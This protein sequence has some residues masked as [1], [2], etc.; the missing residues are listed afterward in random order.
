MKIDF[1][2][3]LLKDYDACWNI[4][5]NARLKMIQSGLHQWSVTYPST[6]DIRNDIESGIAFVLTVDE[7]IAVYGAVILNGEPRYQQ[8][9]GEW[10]TH[11]DYYAIH[12]FATLPEFQREGFAK[13]FIEKINSMCELEHVPSI[14]VDTHISNLPMVNLLSSMGFCYCGIVDYG[15]HGLRCAFEKITMEQQ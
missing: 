5:N 13:V 2:T 7:K 14:K 9:Q 12:R 6:Q 8:L 1:R 15:D 11:G 4:I 10:M 3:A